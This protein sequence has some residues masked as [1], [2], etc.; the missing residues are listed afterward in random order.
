MKHVTCRH[1]FERYSNIKFHKI[2][3]VG[4]E[5]NARDPML[6]YT[7]TACLLLK[8]ISFSLSCDVTLTS[9]IWDTRH[10]SYKELDHCII[11][12]LVEMFVRQFCHFAFRFHGKQTEIPVAY[13]TTR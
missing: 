13:K 10:H 3:P 2:R 6:R 1:I 11:G 5:L 9:F 4:A 12:Q 7:Y 8:K